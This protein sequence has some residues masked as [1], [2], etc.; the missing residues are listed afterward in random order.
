MAYIKPIETMYHGYRF[1]SRLEARWAVFFDALEIPYQYEAEGYNLDGLYY[2]PDFWL[3][4]QRCFF[5]VKGQTPTEQEDRKQYALAEQSRHPVY[6]FVGDIPAPE[7][8]DPSS[9][10]HWEGGFFYGEYWDHYQ[11][12]CECPD[13]GALGIV[14]GGHTTMFAPFC[15][16]CSDHRCGPLTYDRRRGFA[17]SR[18]LAAYAHA[19]QARFE[20]GEGA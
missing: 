7:D 2:L 19:R 5:E 4:D 14:F 20:H 10:M 8:L 18:L 17:S 11:Y 12:W 3:P 9:P 6:V 15:H 13:C 1:R 16:N